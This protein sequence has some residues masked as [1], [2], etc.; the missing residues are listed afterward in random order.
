M[1]L[2]GKATWIG[3]D[4]LG[5]WTFPRKFEIEGQGCQGDGNS[6]DEKVVSVCIPS[7]NEELASFFAMHLNVCGNSDNLVMP[8]G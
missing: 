5:R 8:Q 4:R 3:C 6:L 2:S 7:V 1:G